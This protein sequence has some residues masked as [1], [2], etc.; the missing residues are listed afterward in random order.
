MRAAIHSLAVYGSGRGGPKP[1]SVLKPDHDFPREG[2][3]DAVH[4]LEELHQADIGFIGLAFH[5][6]DD[7]AGTFGRRHFA[8][9]AACRQLGFHNRRQGFQQMNRGAC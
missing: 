7:L 8:A 3:G 2:R 6:N 4:R 9:A 1:A 5:C